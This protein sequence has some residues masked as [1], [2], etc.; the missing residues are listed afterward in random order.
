[1]L[2][3]SRLTCQC[4]CKPIDAAPALTART[5]MAR[6]KPHV[7]ALVAA[8]LLGASVGGDLGGRQGM[9]TTA[10]A[11]VSTAADLEALTTDQPD[12]IV[13]LA[14]L[15]AN[16]GDGGGRRVPATWAALGSMLDGATAARGWGEED[17]FQAVRTI[18]LAASHA[19]LPSQA[20]PSF[21]FFG[22][23]GDKRE[24]VDQARGGQP[25]AAPAHNLSGQADCTKLTASLG[26]L[27]TPETLPTILVLAPGL[28]RRLPDFAAVS[29]DALVAYT[30]W[31]AS[32]VLTN[33]DADADH[34]SLPGVLT[35]F[36]TRQLRSGG[37]Q[38]GRSL[39]APVVDLVVLE[40]YSSGG[41]ND[42]QPSA[43]AR[44]ARR[45]SNHHSTV[46]YASVTWARPTWARPTGGGGDDD[47]ASHRSRGR[48]RSSSSSSSTVVAS[49]C[50]GADIVT[51]VEHALKSTA[52]GP[53]PREPEIEST[54][55]QPIP[56]SR[57]PLCC[58]GA[59]S[60]EA[61]GTGNVGRD[62]TIDWVDQRLLAP[63]LMELTPAASLELLDLKLPFVI[64]YVPGMTSEGRCDVDPD[65]EI[66]DEDLIEGPNDAHADAASSRS[67]ASAL[68]AE[69]E[70]NRYGAAR[71][72]LR[73]DTDALADAYEA[74]AAR[75]SFGD[76]N[77]AAECW[78]AV[79]LGIVTAAQCH[80]ESGRQL[81]FTW[82]PA[83]THPN[84]TVQR[85]RLDLAPFRGLLS[86]IK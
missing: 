8:A 59:I 34:A 73:R 46:A 29:T 80:A 31:L 23:G 38:G 78:D 21:C 48:R 10:P 45:R 52:A 55:S 65:A 9:T 18:Q 70:A 3:S 30:Q 24:S 68:R 14:V 85:R 83:D 36:A 50:D 16:G 12:A 41:A 33:L 51:C 5:E 22:G 28:R 11:F 75:F 79:A 4:T 82:V 6:H 77:E 27:V 32:P 42:G 69:C 61:L 72:A 37:G 26:V 2:A 43:M 86:S 56:G 66:D 84:K 53:G 62:A 20:V 15:P 7:A 13:L 35:N 44:A 54:G 49:T 67:S 63:L 60:A 47:S 57:L 1:M 76:S 58:V 64:L 25:P 19:M 74:A 39:P 81:V 71:A 17:S 40:V